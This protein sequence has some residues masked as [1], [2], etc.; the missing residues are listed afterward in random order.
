MVIY[1]FYGRVHS[2]LFDP[3]EASRRTSLESTGNFVIV[4]GALVLFNGLAM[5]L[6]GLMTALGITTETTTKWHEIGVTAHQS[7]EV[8]IAVLIVGAVL[9][10]AGRGIARAGRSSNQNTAAR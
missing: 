6:L 7:D 4:L 3:A 9:F 1:W 8:G 2:P 10:L 5:T